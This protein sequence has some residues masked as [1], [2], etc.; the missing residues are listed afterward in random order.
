MT[1]TGRMAAFIIGG[2]PPSCAERSLPRSTAERAFAAARD[3]EGAADVRTITA[4]C[5]VG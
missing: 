4:I 5:G 2:T 3:I 1:L